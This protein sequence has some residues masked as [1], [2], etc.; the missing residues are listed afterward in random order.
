VGIVREN[1]T[2]TLVVGYVGQT[3]NPAMRAQNCA[4]LIEGGRVVFRQL[5]T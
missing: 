5:K 2:I 1:L 4:A 3:S